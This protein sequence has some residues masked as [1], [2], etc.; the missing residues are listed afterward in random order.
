MSSCKGNTTLSRDVPHMI[1]GPLLF[2]V[3]LFLLTLL[4]FSNYSY[5]SAPEPPASFGKSL[6]FGNPSFIGCTVSW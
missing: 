5:N 3:L 1:I 6:N 2:F 4:Y